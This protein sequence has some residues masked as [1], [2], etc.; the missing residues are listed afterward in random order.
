MGTPPPDSWGV[1]DVTVLEGPARV[2]L[3]PAGLRDNRVVVLWHECTG[4]GA[5][6]RWIGTPLGDEVIVERDPW[7]ISVPLGCAA[8]GLSGMVRNGRWV[9]GAPQADTA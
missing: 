9:E 2:Y 5:S 1:P 7:T 3:A 8:C 6:P 4:V